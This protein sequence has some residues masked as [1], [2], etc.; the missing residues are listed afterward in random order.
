MTNI[1]QEGIN[2][3]ET[4]EESVS[5]CACLL[6]YYYEKQKNY[7]KMKKYYKILSKNNIFSLSRLDFYENSQKFN[8]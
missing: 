6:G 8:Y 1:L 7:N 5:N 3:K 2:E 4:F